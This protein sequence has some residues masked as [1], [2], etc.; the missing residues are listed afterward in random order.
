MIK[1]IYSKFHDEVV[2]LYNKEIDGTGLAI[3]RIAYSTIFLAEIIQIFFFRHLIFDR[4]PYIDEG[5]I[6]VTFPLMVWMV[7]VILIILGLFTRMASVVNYFFSLIF[8]GGITSFEYH[9]FYA[10]MGINALLIFMPVSRCWSIDKLRLKIRY[11]TLRSEYVPPSK[12]SVLAYYVPV[13]LGIGFVYVDSIFFKVTSYYWMNGLGM[14]VPASL[15]MITYAEPSFLMNQEWLCK[16]MGYTTLVFEAVFIFFFWFKRFRVPLLIVGFL[17]HIGI[18]LEFPIPLFALG[19]LSIYLLMVPVSYWKRLRI[20]TTGK[21]RLK[22]FYDLEC[23]L[24]LRTKLIVSH[25]DV[26]KR[27]VFLPV[28]GNWEHEPALAGLSEQELLLNIHSVDNKGNVYT[29][30]DTYIRALESIFY[31]KPLGWLLRIPGIYH[32]SKKV[33]LYVAY[34]RTTERC[35]EGNCNIAPAAVRGK[36]STIKLL[37][38]FS[39]A[40]LKVT[41]LV[42][43]LIFLM[44]LQLNTTYNSALVMDLRDMSGVDKTFVGKGLG[45]VSSKVMDISK[46]FFGITSHSVFMDAHFNNYNHIVAVVFVAPDGKSSFLPIIDEQ[47]RPG[48]YIYGPNWVK[49]TFR[50][51]SPEVNMEQLTEGIRDFTAFW[52]HKH[53]IDLKD[54][55]FKILVK[56]INVPHKWE[57]DF[58][59]K[60]IQKPWVDAGEV[61]W[62]D[63]QFKIIKCIS[64]ELI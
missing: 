2:R 41:G 10:Y 26:R 9:M 3:F 37:S 23:P 22:V 54:A 18:L 64:I 34:N 52:A 46:T 21:P 29:G 4:I 63:S 40:D 60:Q 28:Q 15:P 44:V 36:E 19:V 39:L 33:Y 14:W 62:E 61:K 27:I 24:C 25:F 13:L 45:S 17:L 53:S 31:L 7:F 49:W 58:L 48:S 20:N 56:K 8:I 11:S 51:N 38:N 50:V 59:S 32:I 43:G 47:G 57:K 16:L 35:T 12:V 30:V 1:K 55:T 6:D 5:A 42:Y